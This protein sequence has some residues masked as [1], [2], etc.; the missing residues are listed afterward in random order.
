MRLARLT[1]M[2]LPGRR[3]EY[4]RFTRPDDLNQPDAPEAAVFHSGE[5]PIFDAIDRLRIIFRDGVFDAEPR[6]I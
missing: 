3:D 4:W 2:G 1:A 6:T 5:A